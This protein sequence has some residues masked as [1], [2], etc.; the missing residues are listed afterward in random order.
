M[1]YSKVVYDGRTVI[2]LTSDT[3]TAGSL[4]EGKT[5]HDAKGD[6]ITGTMKKPT[7]SDD[8][9]GN[10]RFSGITVTAS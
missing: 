5:A 10:L 6:S 9:N 8:G 1:G 7:I 4:E 3:I 2:D